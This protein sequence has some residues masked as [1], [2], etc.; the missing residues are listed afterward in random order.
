MSLEY[1]I[2]KFHIQIQQ[3]QYF[4]KNLNPTCFALLV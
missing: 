1:L 4:S 3:R 2:F